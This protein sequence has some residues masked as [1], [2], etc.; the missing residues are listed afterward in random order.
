MVID[1]LRPRVALDLEA[2][3]QC[4]AANPS[5]RRCLPTVSKM[6]DALAIVR[7]DTVIRWNRVPVGNLIRLA[8]EA[9]SRNASAL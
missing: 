4:V 1:L 6:Y 7:P 9:E 8:T 5:Q 2:T 3:N